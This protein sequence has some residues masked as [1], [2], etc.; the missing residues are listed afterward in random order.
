[1]FTSSR[2]DA[3]AWVKYGVPGICAVGIFYD[4]YLVKQGKYK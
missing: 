2:P 1:M 4:L 3:M